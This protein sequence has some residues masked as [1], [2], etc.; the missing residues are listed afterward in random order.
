SPNQGF[1]GHAARADG[2]DASLPY[3]KVNYD[4]ALIV[5]RP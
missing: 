3:M 5:I 1:Q 4:Q 2:A